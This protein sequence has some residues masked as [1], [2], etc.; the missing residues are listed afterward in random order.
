MTFETAISVID[1]TLG[2]LEESTRLNLLLMG[3][4]PFLS[5]D[6]MRGLVKYIRVYYPNRQIFIKTVTNGTLVHGKEQD[7]LSE[8]KDIFFASLSVDGKKKP[9]IKTGANHM[10]RLILTFLPGYTVLRQKR[11]W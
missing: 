9:T 10:I 5:F 4:E 3:G 8:N 11:A 7:W 1:E 2:R 6:L